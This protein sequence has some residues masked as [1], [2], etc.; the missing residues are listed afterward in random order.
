MSRMGIL[1]RG[2]KFATCRFLLLERL[3][4]LQTCR[5]VPS[6][7][8][9][10]GRQRADLFAFFDQHT[11]NA[12]QFLAQLAEVALVDGVLGAEAACLL[13]GL[14]LLVAVRELPALPVGNLLLP[15]PQAGE[16]GL[17]LLLQLTRQLVQPAP[18][19]RQLAALFVGR[20]EAI[21]PGG[22]VPLQAGQARL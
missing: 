11:S 20:G 2:G 22:L 4:K 14:R 21:E 7:S 3:S 10:M 5:H 9:G 13:G 16:Q 17:L 6:L 12:L 1:S 19:R 15:L 8:R 18:L